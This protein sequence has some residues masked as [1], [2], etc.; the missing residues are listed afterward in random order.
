MKDFYKMNQG[1]EY[2]DKEI[3]LQLPDKKGKT[4]IINLSIYIYLYIYL[5]LFSKK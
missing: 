2:N 3:I 1:K 5:H 4:G